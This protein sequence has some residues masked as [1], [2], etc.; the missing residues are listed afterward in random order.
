MTDR[1]IHFKVPRHVISGIGAIAELPDVL[2]EL[3]SSN[4]VVFTDPGVFKTEGFQ[5]VIKTLSEAGINPPI[6]NGIVCEP[7]VESLDDTLA[8]VREHHAD[9]IIGVGGG[10]TM[11]SS[12][13]T[14]CLLTNEVSVR[15]WYGFDK[16]AKPGIPTILLPTTTGTGSEVTRI[17]VFYDEETRMKEAVYSDML[18]AYAAILDPRLT[19]SLPVKYTA[20]TG[21]DALSHAVEG[22]ISVK[23]TIM[24][25]ALSLGSIRTFFN[26]LQISCKDGN[27]IEARARMQEAVMMAAIAFGHAS[28]TAVHALGYPLGS[29]YH[30]PHGAS[31][32]LVMVPVLEYSLAEASDRYAEMAIALGIA[33]P[34]ASEEANAQVFLDA[35]RTLAESVPIP[36]SLSEL[37]IPESAIPGMAK[38]A[39]TIRRCLDVHPH[40]FTVEEVEELYRSIY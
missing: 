3:E 21:M 31:C 39:M 27:D 10:S 2:N 18:Y 7:T 13:T 11:D 36:K 20:S 34:N 40:Q 8:F 1:V 14:S 12:K 22:Y 33:D 25:D 15:N 30:V 32:A 37:D 6:F 28:V 26:Y 5:L 23:N 29:E 4:C 16:I 24:T 9:V 35:M 19:L 17:A 38:Q